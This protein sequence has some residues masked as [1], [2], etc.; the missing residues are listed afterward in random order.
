MEDGP[1]E[2]L[3][4]DFLIKFPDAIISE[5]TFTTPE[6][7]ASKDYF[8]ILTEELT[9]FKNQ[10]NSTLPTQNSEF[11]QIVLGGDNTITFSSLLA[12]IERVKDPRAVGYIQFDSHGE[13]N[14]Y[15]GSD[16][17]NFHGMY[18]RPFFDKFDIPE[19]DNLV[20]EKLKSEQAIFIGDM[21]LDGD[22]PQ[23]F[24]KM[25]FKTLTFEE[26]QRD[27]EQ[28]IEYLHSFLAD[29]PY[30]HVNFDIDIFNR[31]VAGATGIPEDGKW[32]KAEIFEILEIIS[33]HPNVS[34]DLSE[35]NPRCT[36]AERTIKLAQE[37]LDLI[38]N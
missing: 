32:Q 12:L 23:F 24:Q 15:A 19:I 33:K 35:I 21:I 7:I 28:F 4:P 11:M 18:M 1:D 34:F 29:Y 10:I 37:M 2:I 6:E 31:D 27:K 9:S 5:F 14:S 38:L 3:T 20:P 25:N 30:I 13:S 22:E 16:S 36:G 17:K 26:Y 8:Q